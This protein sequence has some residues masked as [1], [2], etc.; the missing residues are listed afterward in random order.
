MGNEVLCVDLQHIHFFTGSGKTT[1]LRDIARLLS[2]SKRVMIVD[3]SNQIGG[4]G[5]IPHSSIGDAR[6]MQI[7]LG[8]EQ[9]NVMLEAVQNHNPGIF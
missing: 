5:N 9:H 8:Q 3:T 1:L 6:R 4:G 7:P 2:K